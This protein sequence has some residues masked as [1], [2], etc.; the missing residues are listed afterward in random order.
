MDAY[1]DA[2]QPVDEDFLNEILEQD[3]QGVNAMYL[4]GRPSTALETYESE[5]AFTKKGK[6]L[7]D[8][9]QQK[10][11][12]KNRYKTTRQKRQEIERK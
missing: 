2:K 3:D 12:L 6:R 8:R 11:E 9:R 10:Q 7:Q 5:R 4:Q 1:E